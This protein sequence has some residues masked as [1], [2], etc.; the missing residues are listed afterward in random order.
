MA[1]APQVEQ[2]LAAMTADFPA[3]ETLSG[4]EARAVTRARR[5]A[6]AAPEQVAEIVDRRIEAWSGPLPVR[7]YR[8]LEPAGQPPPVVVFLHGGG[9]VICDLDSHDGACRSLGNG[10][11][12]VVVSV[13]YRLA[14]EHPW[15]AAADDALAA[16]DW[17]AAHS[18]ELDVDAARL[19]VA[20]DSAGGNLAA[21]TTLALRDRGG[22]ALRAQILVYPVI[23]PDFTTASYRDNGHGYFLTAAAMRWYWEQYDPGL[24]HAEDP[25]LVPLR[26]GSLVGAAPAFIITAELD[27]LRDEGEAYAA[28]LAAAGVPVWSKRWDGLFHGFL[29]LDQL[30]IAAEARTEL[31]QA[32]RPVLS[33]GVEGTQQACR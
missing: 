7:V 30:D 4:A 25:H 27:P 32:V 5:P 19:L 14:P 17:V 23:A 29:F 20:G 12:A 15:P 8:P 3:V 11:G 16:V 1:L 2:L 6:P 18:A 21:V 28:A 31:Y 9:W 26:A 10:L 33:G 13:D 24:A 22:P